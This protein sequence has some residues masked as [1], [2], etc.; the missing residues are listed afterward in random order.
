MPLTIISAKVAANKFFLREL[1]QFFIEKR[2]GVFGDSDFS[3]TKEDFKQYLTEK[4]YSS[5]MIVSDELIKEHLD[6][7]KN[8]FFARNIEMETIIPKVRV[9]NYEVSS[10]NEFI[11]RGSNTEHLSYFR[12]FLDVSLDL[13]IL[14]DRISEVN[15]DDEEGGDA[16]SEGLSDRPAQLVSRSNETLFLITQSQQIQFLDRTTESA[17]SIRERAVFLLLKRNF[18]NYHSYRDLFEAVSRM[19]YAAASQYSQNLSTLCRSAS[20][21]KTLINNTVLGLRKKLYE[22]SGNPDTIQTKEGRISCYRLVY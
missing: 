4:K 7:V 3:F 20:Q 9:L 22:L 13:G 15:S 6:L 19:N 14:D 10:N 12:R 21:K 5:V 17:L 18:K 1:I 8:N 2:K 11:I 16:A